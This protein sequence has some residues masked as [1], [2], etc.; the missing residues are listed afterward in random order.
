MDKAAVS[1]CASSTIHLLTP[2]LGFLE[3]FIEA[4]KGSTEECQLSVC[5]GV[6]ARVWKG[7][8]WFVITLLMEWPPSFMKSIHVFKALLL[9]RPHVR[10]PHRWYCL[11]WWS[12]KKQWRDYFLIPEEL[13]ISCSTPVFVH[14]FGVMQVCLGSLTTD[15]LPGIPILVF[16]TT[17]LYEAK[18]NKG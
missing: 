17:S 3:V 6:C 12:S 7:P 11:I 16:D 8:V 14:L 9:D 4:S 18:E 2:V 13:C 5:V 10:K 1:G 15:P